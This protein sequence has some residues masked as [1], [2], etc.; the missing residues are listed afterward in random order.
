M[1]FSRK[2]KLKKE[3]DEKLVSSIKE[4][5]EA[6]QSAKVIEE[7]TDDYNLNVIAER[8]RAESIHYYLYKEARVRRVLIK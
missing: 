2:G 7:L 8:K 6:L 5:K 4:T 1:L 3:F